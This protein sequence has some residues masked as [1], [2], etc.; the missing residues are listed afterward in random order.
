MAVHRGKSINSF[1]SNFDD[2]KQ[3]AECHPGIFDEEEIMADFAKQS[4]QVGSAWYLILV[5]FHILTL[6]PY[7]LLYKEAVKEQVR[8]LANPDLL[9]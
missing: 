2:L 3:L 8:I 9:N 6:I 4:D 5:G 1:K 7:V